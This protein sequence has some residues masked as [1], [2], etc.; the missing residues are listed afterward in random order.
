MGIDNQEKLSAKLDELSI[1]DDQQLLAASKA[2]PAAPTPVDKPQSAY[3]LFMKS[4]KDDQEFKK[5]I[6]S[7]KQMKGNFLEEVSK[8]WKDM[9]DA[10]K[11]PFYD[12]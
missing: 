3:M 8:K 4:L 9:D 1:E 5:H 7:V 2:A 6:E 12:Q 10:S 11:Q